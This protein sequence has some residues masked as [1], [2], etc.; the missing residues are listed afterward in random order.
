MNFS[1]NPE[2]LTDEI[3]IKDEGKTYITTQNIIESHNSDIKS[4]KSI[5]KFTNF[6]KI[7][8]K[9]LNRQWQCS[10]C[11]RDFQHQYTLMRHLSTHTNERNFSCDE[12]GKSFRQ[13][14]TLS[15][16]RAIH[17]VQRPYSC[18]LCSKSFNRISTLISHRKTHSDVKPYKCHICQKGFHQKGNLRNHI[19]IHTN[20]RPYRCQHCNKGFNQMSNLV[21]HKLKTHSNESISIWSCHKCDLTFPKRTLLRT[22]ELDVHQI[23]EKSPLLYLPS[24]RHKSYT[25]KRQRQSSND[26]PVIDNNSILMPTIKTIAMNIVK[27]RKEVPF[28]I[29]HF[30]E[31]L[32][33]LV[34]VIDYGNQ[35]ILRPVKKEDFSALKANRKNN[36]EDIAIPIVATVYQILNQFGQPEFMVTQPKDIYK[37]MNNFKQQV[38]MLFSD[39]GPNVANAVKMVEISKTKKKISTE[40]KNEDEN[41]CLQIQHDIKKEIVDNVND[42]KPKVI[43]IMGQPD[44]WNKE[45]ESIHG[46]F[47]A[48]NE[49]KQV[50]L[51]YFQCIIIYIL[52]IVLLGCIFKLPL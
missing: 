29:L 37:L 19:F 20:E 43:T 36:V 8:G 15:Q 51:I 23:Q 25:T 13:L 41:Y 17:S 18:E 45:I 24:S 14:S 30:I 38:Q 3:N 21:C 34:R 9:P 31:G 42:Q 48:P 35:S 49:V 52:V 1:S 6:T 5:K 28:A 33:L 32:P 10:I 27:S 44:W 12:C 11:K 46:P 26:L 4:T 39:D 22:H 2:N 47:L 50:N 40:N 7:A 16:H